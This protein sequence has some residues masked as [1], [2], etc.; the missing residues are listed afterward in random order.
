M[1]LGTGTSRVHVRALSEDL[2]KDLQARK[3]KPLSVEG[4]EEGQWVVVDLDAI[5]VHIF[6]PDTRAY[7]ALENLWQDAPQERYEGPDKA[8]RRG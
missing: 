8:R 2:L 4:V 5:V 1:V 7:Y 3:T 6:E